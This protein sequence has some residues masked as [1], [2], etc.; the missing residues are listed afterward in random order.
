MASVMAP[1]SLTRRPVRPPLQKDPH[2]RL[3]VAAS[4]ED[5]PGGF[6]TSRPA[7]AAHSWKIHLSAREHD[8]VERLA[9]LERTTAKEAVLSAVRRRL[10]EVAAPPEGA[11]TSDAPTGSDAPSGSVL[12]RL[13][14]AGAVGLFDGPEDLSANK[15]YLE[16]LGE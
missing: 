7:M 14:A 12:E 15:A 5:A 3:H 4:D 10:D 13:E 8:E 16:G 6:P 9:R 11:A 2:P 1:V